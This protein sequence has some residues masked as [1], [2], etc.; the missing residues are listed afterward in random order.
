MLLEGDSVTGQLKRFAPAQSGGLK[1]NHRDVVARF[2]SEQT[3]GGAPGGPSEP[4]LVGPAETLN[5]FSA[6][7]WKARLDANRIDRMAWGQRVAPQFLC[8]TRIARQSRTIQLA[9]AH[10]WSHSTG[11]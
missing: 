1:R 8:R 5:G 10:N 7:F 2:N 4:S 6:R 9:T 3:C 11:G